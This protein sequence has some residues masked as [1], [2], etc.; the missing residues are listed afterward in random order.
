M[1]LT[2]RNEEQHYRNEA[3]L[4]G[5]PKKFLLVEEQVVMS[6]PVELRI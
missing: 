3:T 1:E 5:A 4:N 6:R 2:E